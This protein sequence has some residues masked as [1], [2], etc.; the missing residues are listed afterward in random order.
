MDMS[1]GLCI[2]LKIDLQVEKKGGVERNM[3]VYVCVHVCTCEEYPLKNIYIIVVAAILPMR[4]NLTTVLHN[5]AVQL[6][7][8]TPCSYHRHAPSGHDPAEARYSDSE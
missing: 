3:Y 8:L 4:C 6:S 2:D 1:A 5:S 7:H